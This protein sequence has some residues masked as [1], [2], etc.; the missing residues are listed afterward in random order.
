MT[1]QHRE[2]R[3]LDKYLSAIALGFGFWLASAASILLSR[4]GDGVAAVWLASA[5]A[6]VMLV[7]RERRT[8]ILDY[9]ALAVA[10]LVSNLQFGSSLTSGL[11]YVV[12]NLGQTALALLLVDKFAGGLPVKAR[13]SVRTFALILFLTGVV[14][15]SV[16]GLIFASFT[17]AAH[18][19]PIFKT[20]WTFLSSNALGYALVLPLLLYTE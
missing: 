18:G 12:F 8:G 14:A 1:F 10:T 5:V 7:R 13:P 17:Y 2:R 4:V 20:A 15:D 3:G 11:L 16:T 19:W 6:F 9:A